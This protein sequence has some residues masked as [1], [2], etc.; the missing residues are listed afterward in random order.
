MATGEDFLR[1][2]AEKVHQQYADVLRAGKIRVNGE[3]VSWST[4]T[5]TELQLA[6]FCEAFIAK[7]LS[8]P[9]F[10]GATDTMLKHAPYLF[11]KAVSFNYVLFEVLELLR[12]KTGAICSI[13]TRSPLG[14][15]MVEY[16]ADILPGFVLQVCVA[17][18]GRNNIVFHDPENAETHVKGTLYCLKAKI[19]MAPKP[20][21]TPVYSLHMSLGLSSKLL[22]LVD[23]RA[24]TTELISVS[25][26]LLIQCPFE[27]LTGRTLLETIAQR[28]LLSKPLQFEVTSDDP[29]QRVDFEAGSFHGVAAKVLNATF[30]ATGIHLKDHQLPKWS[31]RDHTHGSSTKALFRLPRLS[32]G[33]TVRSWS[34]RAP[35]A[36]DQE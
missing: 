1:I 26:P 2:S 33:P 32:S 4:E 12:R 15:S 30:G 18:K 34:R 21:F 23:G 16:S 9:A 5:S 35:L 6:A 27:T 3:L 13:E 7:L 20:N 25:E 17:F 19:D 8:F 14:K 10:L 29:E 36:M 28:D 31:H 22:Q 11:C 24:K